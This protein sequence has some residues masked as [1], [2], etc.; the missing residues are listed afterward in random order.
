MAR[1]FI[2]FFFFLAACFGVRRVGNLKNR[3]ETTKN[4]EAL[5]QALKKYPNIRQA[6]SGGDCGLSYY[7]T[8]DF[9]PLLHFALRRKS[10]KSALVSLP[11]GLQFRKMSFFYPH[12]AEQKN[13][14]R[15]FSLWTKK[16][17]M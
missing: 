1:T 2:G 8:P 7:T 3:K 16:Q 14:I 15:S 12:T 9:F 10:L 6:L 4:D 13:I 11:K 17:E 5:R